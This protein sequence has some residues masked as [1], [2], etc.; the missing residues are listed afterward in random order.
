MNPNVVG[1]DL[2]LSHTGIVVLPV[3]WE[4]SPRPWVMNYGHA[5]SSLSDVASAADKA[6]RLRSIVQEICSYVF[7]PGNKVVVVFCEDHAYGLA[8]KRG[9]QLAELHGAVK[10]GLLRLG[11]VVIPVN[12]S[13]VRRLLLG[14]RGNAKGVKKEVFRRLKAAGA[15]FD[16]DDLSDAFAVANF[17]RSEL[18]LSAM[19]LAEK[20]EI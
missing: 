18:G 14:K 13:R 3:D 5:G 1:L 15:P 7:D 9:I 4:P 19:T 8:G 20:D 6:M 16:S 10:Y 17:G 12:V 11:V 2:S